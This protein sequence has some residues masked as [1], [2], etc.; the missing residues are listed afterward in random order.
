MEVD[1]YWEISRVNGTENL[2]T[3]S[4]QYAYDVARPPRATLPTNIK[5]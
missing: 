4:L 1:T 3:Y 2:F 5:S